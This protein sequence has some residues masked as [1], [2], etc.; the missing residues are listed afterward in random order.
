MIDIKLQQLF[1]DWQNRPFEWGYSDCC[2]L[3]ADAVRRLHGIEPPTV[4]PYET[5]RGAL[6]VVHDFGGYQGIIKAAG[7]RQVQLQAAQ[8]GDIAI[9]RV[10]VEEGQ[11]GFGSSMAVVT[12]INAHTTGKHG[13]V[14]VPKNSWLEVWGVRNA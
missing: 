2:Q 10:P 4:A 14:A 13:L 11:S 7:L 12:G 6:R 8:R 5:I 3:A 1:A 9:V